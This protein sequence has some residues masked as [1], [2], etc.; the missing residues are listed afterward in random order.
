M[1]NV[2]S[3][4]WIWN[5]Q[6]IS[7]PGRALYDSNGGH[8]CLICAPGKLGFYRC[9]EHIIMTPNHVRSNERNLFEFDATPE[10]T[11]FMLQHRLTLDFVGYVRINLNE[12]RVGSN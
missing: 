5:S 6:F 9:A 1:L 12:L 8:S 10:W 2:Q 3:S 7:S 11:M 4:I